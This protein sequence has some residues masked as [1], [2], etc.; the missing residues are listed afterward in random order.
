MRTVLYIDQV[1]DIQK[2]I[3]GVAPIGDDCRVLPSE[4]RP[5]H[6]CRAVHRLRRTYDGDRDAITRCIDRLLSLHLCPP[7]RR[8]RRKRAVFRERNAVGTR[9]GGCEGTEMERRLM[10]GACSSTALTTFRV[11]RTLR[12]KTPDRFWPWSDRQGGRR[13]RHFSP[14]RQGTQAECSH[15]KSFRHQRPRDS[16]AVQV[17]HETDYFKSLSCQGFRKMTADKPVPPVISAFIKCFNHTGTG[18]GKAR[19]QRK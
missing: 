13:N 14:L 8:Y 11:A 6:P 18:V 12:R 19:R 3:A 10:S 17:P 9:A 5:V 1:F 7:V 15:R 16:L 4:K 2:R